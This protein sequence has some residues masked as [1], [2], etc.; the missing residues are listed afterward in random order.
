MPTDCGAHS[1]PFMTRA[2]IIFAMVLLCVVSMWTTYQSLADSILPEPTLAI[3]LP[4]GTVWKCSVFALMFSVAIDLMLFALKVAIID[5]H[6]RLT[7]AGFIGLTIVASVSIAFNMDVLYRYAKKDFYITYAY[8]QMR[9]NYDN[10]LAD[11][12]HTLTER[13]QELMRTVASQEGELEAETK[14]LRQAPAGYGPLARQE[15]YR[16]TVLSKTA[17][18]DI[19]AIDEALL[20]K[21]R[22]DELLAAEMPRDIA[23]IQNLQNELR[24]AVKDL[25]A[26]VGKPL[27]A[28]VETDS[29]LLAVFANLLDPKQ[30]G[31][32]EI[33]ILLLAILL[34]LGDIV[35]YSLVPNKTP[36]RPRRFLRPM[37]DFGTPEVVPPQPPFLTGGGEAQRPETDEGATMSPAVVDREGPTRRR[38]M[39]FR[40]RR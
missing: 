5:G 1:M 16:L 2:V 17:Q 12:Q 19:Q 34:D 23:G 26:L 22:A 3:P 29:P 9:T 4:I 8:N 28:P 31:L 40:R 27:P 36:E 14:G 10:Y 11:V 30:V 7:V 24:V 15:D 21:R 35:G 37:P 38:S 25:G 32:F 20:A 39:S 6:K 13:R 18:V 33:F